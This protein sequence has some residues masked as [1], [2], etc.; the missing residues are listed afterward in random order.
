MDKPTVGIRSLDLCKYV[1]DDYR[2]IMSSLAPANK[3]VGVVSL[4]ELPLWGFV[5]LPHPAPI[6]FALKWV[7]R[8]MRCPQSWLLMRLTAST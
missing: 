8:W 3:E 5:S 7:I 2:P 6:D 1:V 4:F